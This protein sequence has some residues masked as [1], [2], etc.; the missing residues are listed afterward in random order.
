MDIDSYV[1]S[2]N[3]EGQGTAGRFTI[4]LERAL[5]MTAHFSFPDRDWWVLKFVQAAVAAGA[6]QIKLHFEEDQWLFRHDGDS[7][8]RL[9]LLDGLGKEGPKKQM[10]LCLRAAWQDPA[11]EVALTT[12]YDGLARSMTLPGDGVW[13]ELPTCPWGED[14]GTLL[15]CRWK[16]VQAL[17]SKRIA[18]FR[19]AFHL[20]P[21]RVWLDRDCIN[22]PSEG[23]RRVPSWLWQASS[24]GPRTLALQPVSPKL[25]VTAAEERCS[26]DCDAQAQEREALEWLPLYQDV[27]CLP[28]W[29]LVTLTPDIGLHK[30]RLV[31]FGVEIDPLQ[32]PMS[33]PASGA[34][35]ILSTSGLQLDA[36]GCKVVEDAIWQ[37]R[38]EQLG[39][40]YQDLYKF[41]ARTAPQL[42]IV[43]LFKGY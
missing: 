31:H 4:D 5:A 25:K 2:L 11:S 26:W 6:A 16:G 33:T 30:V 18:R 27:R 7:I 8:G 19:D 20:A 24:L 21:A 14:E 9:S 42:N 1:K 41:F 15:I 38:C 29:G 13:K 32:A 3:D 36:S 40:A 22:D 10:A 23:D 17:T 39:H 35:S 28:C 43:R 12:H 34:L 37:K